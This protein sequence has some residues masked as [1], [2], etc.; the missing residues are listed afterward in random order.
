[1]ITHVVIIVV[2]VVVVV[3]VVAVVVVVMVV[4]DSVRKVPDTVPFAT[5]F[6]ICV[7][8]KQLKRAL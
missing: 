1:M 5:A 3:V 7:K 8:L 2:V 6:S 4:V